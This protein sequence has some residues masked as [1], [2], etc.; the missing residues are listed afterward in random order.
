LNLVS[1]RRPSLSSLA[2]FNN[3][4]IIIVIIISVAHCCCCMLLQADEL[5]EEEMAEADLMAEDAA[6][7][8]AAAQEGVEALEQQ[9]AA[10]G[11]SYDAFVQASQVSE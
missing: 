7:N 4:I 1:L 2:V 9:A 6:V 10:G 5:E 11:F 8:M 3:F